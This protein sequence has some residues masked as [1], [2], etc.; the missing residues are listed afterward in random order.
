MKYSIEGDPFPVVICEMEEGESLICEAGAMAWMTPN[1]KMETSS[2]G[3]IGK[4]LGRMMTREHMFMNR[5]TAEHGPGQ[6]A[7]ASCFPGC[8]RKLDI[9]PGRE[10]IVQK[11]SYLASTEGVTLSTYFQKKLTS[12]AFGGEGFVMQKLSGEGAAFVEL[13]GYITEYNLEEGQE[14]VIDTGYMAAM[15]GSCSM[16]IVKVPGVKNVFFGGEGVFNTIVK[17]PGQI[18]LQT[19]PIAKMAGALHRFLPSSS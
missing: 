13:D 6:I 17:G 10:M 1:M 19:M 8:I 2:N 16:D 3:G 7:F 18:W 9:A 12:G 4:M 5:Y 15:T 11:S 14:M